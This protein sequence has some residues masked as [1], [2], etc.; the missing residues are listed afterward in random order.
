M[1]IILASSSPRRRE[2]LAQTGLDFLVIPSSCPEE[3]DWTRTPQE[4]AMQL[5]KQKADDVAAKIREKAIVIGADTIVVKDGILG[6]PKDENEARQMLQKLQGETHEVITGL[7]L[8]EALEGKS[9]ST[10]ERTLVRM[11]PLSQEEIDSYVETK[12]PMDKAGGYGIQGKAAL[13]IQEIQGCYFNVVGL[14]LH[15]LWKLLKKLGIVF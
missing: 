4:V 9:V 14:P 10:F 11:A 5:A 7:C 12:E 15:R 13:F 8:V 3:A 1:K 6:K 2:L